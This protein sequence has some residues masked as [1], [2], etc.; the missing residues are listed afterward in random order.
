MHQEELKVKL[1]SDLS[2]LNL[3][4]DEVDLFI[5]PFSKT[6][7]G[8]YFPVYNDKETKPKIY[9]YPY[10]NYVGDL[11]PYAKILGTAIHELCHHIQYTSGSFVRNKGVMHNTQFWK[12]YNHY[13]SRAVSLKM[14]GEDYCED[15]TK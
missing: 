11:I 1:L 8:R 15:S 12:L 5:R 7:Y 14:I 6:F 3:P 10:S 2:N 4:I 13:M 9:V